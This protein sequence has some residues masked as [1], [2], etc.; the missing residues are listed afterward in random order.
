MLY[1][2]L[3]WHNFDS[4]FD[5]KRLIGRKFE[6][7]GVQADIKHFPLEVNKSGKPYICVWYRGEDKEFVCRVP[8]A[9]CLFD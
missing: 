7:G 6:D 8:F 1:D 4:V 2:F 5:A 9:I 3:I